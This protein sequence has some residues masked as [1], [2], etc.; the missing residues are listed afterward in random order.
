[1]AKIKESPLGI[2]LG[3]IGMIASAK[4]K[5]INYVRV[6][7]GSV[8]NPQTDKQLTQRQKFSVTYEVPPA[9]I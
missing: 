8:A 3:K 7:A 2:I 5:G 9:P 1:M 4:W 6:L